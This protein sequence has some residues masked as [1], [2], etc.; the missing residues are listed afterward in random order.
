MAGIYYNV[1][2]FLI[3]PNFFLDMAEILNDHKLREVARK[4]FE[5]IFPNLTALH[6]GD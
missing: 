1:P 4:S 5:Q 2:L 3:F 6:C